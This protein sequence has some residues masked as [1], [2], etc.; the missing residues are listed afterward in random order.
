M[1]KE[2]FINGKKDSCKHA[3]LYH[4]RKQEQAADAHMQAYLNG[5]FENDIVA[6]LQL[7]FLVSAYPKNTRRKL[8]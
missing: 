6:T 7:S 3:G 2:K 5:E 8:K 1:A 4:N